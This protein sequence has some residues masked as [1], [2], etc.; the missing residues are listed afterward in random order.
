MGVESLR[1]HHVTIAYYPDKKRTR[2]DTGEFTLLGCIFCLI[3]EFLFYKSAS[4]TSLV[5]IPP[6]LVNN[7]PVILNDIN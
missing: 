7:V 4:S 3:K 5:T 1:L 2:I 6:C